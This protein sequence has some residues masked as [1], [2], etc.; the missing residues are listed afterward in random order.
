MD[1]QRRGFAVMDKDARREIAKLGGRAAQD[2]GNAHQFTKEEAREAGRKS[3]EARRA[4]KQ[5]ATA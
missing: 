4:K 5:A 1:K 3:Q 2:S